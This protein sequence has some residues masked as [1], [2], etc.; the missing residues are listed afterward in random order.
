M[1]TVSNSTPIPQ[2][3]RLRWVIV[4]LLLAF[5][6]VAFAQDET[7]PTDPNVFR[8]QV[9]LWWAFI[10][11]IFFAGLSESV[12]QSFVLFINRVKPSRF[13]PSVL[14]NTLLFLFGYFET[15]FVIW[16]TAKFLL[17][18]DD[19]ILQIMYAVG[20]SYVPLLFSFLTLL[21]YL[22][23]GIVRILYLLSYTIM[24]NR[25]HQAIGF[26]VRE[27]VVTV[28]LSFVV[29]MVVRG[30]IGRPLRSIVKAVQNRIAGTPL[31]QNIMKAMETVDSQATKRSAN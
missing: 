10:P 8:E 22:G 30:T 21:P 14:M 16:L 29:L 7:L 23:P 1:P 19:I 15:V 11:T 2:W 12:G 13:I 3:W 28:L 26:P 24:V 20:V 6:A 18:Y 31:E 4:L 17:G 5:P 9:E 25:L 27:A